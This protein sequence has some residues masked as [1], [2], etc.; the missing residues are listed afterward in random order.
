MHMWLTLETASPTNNRGSPFFTGGLAASL[1]EAGALLLGSTSPRPGRHP[2]SSPDVTSSFRFSRPQF[3]CNYNHHRPTLMPAGAPWSID[4]APPIR[5][6]TPSLW[7]ACSVD[8]PGDNALPS[9]CPAALT[10]SPTTSDG[11]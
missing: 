4:A 8:E 9:P 6:K 3:E 11:A 1:V 2:S 10:F 5:P 7:L